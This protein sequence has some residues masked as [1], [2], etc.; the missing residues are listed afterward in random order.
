MARERGRSVPWSDPTLQNQRKPRSQPGGLPICCTQIPL[1]HKDYPEDVGEMPEDGGRSASE[2]P[3]PKTT[4]FVHVLT[5]L[6]NDD[7]LAGLDLV[8]VEL[9]KRLLHYATAG[10]ELLEMA[11]E[12]LVLAVRARARLGQALSAAQHAEN[13]LQVLG[14]GEW[15]PKS[16]RPS[17]SDDPRVTGEET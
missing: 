11:N 14:V 2:E 15:R 12:G 1:G 5:E 7:L 10:S 17:W 6:S 9:E 16:T 3:A 8:L 13:H 4:D